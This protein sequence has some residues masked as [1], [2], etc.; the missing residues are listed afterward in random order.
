MIHLIAA[1]V[2]MPV[3][4]LGK[5]PKMMLCYACIPE[6][7][8]CWVGLDLELTSSLFCCMSPALILEFL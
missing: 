1:M 8:S 6:P 7:I 3:L 4:I 2:K 5:L